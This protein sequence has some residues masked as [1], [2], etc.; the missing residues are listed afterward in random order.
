MT[1][2]LR[3]ADRGPY[4]YRLPARDDPAHQPGIATR[5]LPHLALAAYDAEAADPRDWA[6]P[7]TPELT[8]TVG[9][10]PA[11]FAP[12]ERPVHLREL[13]PFPGDALDPAW[14]GGDIVVQACATTPEA[15]LAA[16]PAGVTPRW[17]QTGSLRRARRDGPNTTPRD[18]LGFR[19]GSWNVR[20]DADRL[21][22][23]WIDRGDRTAMV[24]GTYMVVRRIEIDLE[25]WE[26][27]PVA[28]QERVIGRHK[29]TGAPLGRRSE[30]D[31]VV[32]EWLPRDSHALQAAPRSNNG[33][34]LLRRGYSYDRGVV[35]IAFTRDP[36]RYYVPMQR[37]L[38]E[39]DAL[40]G[41]TRHT[42]SA[43]FAVPP[44]RWAPG[45]RR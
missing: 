25:R 21:R 38:A 43:L 32:H 1:P 44:A 45:A 27:L 7:A 13:P 37:R 4:S 24:G 17:L 18:P 40:S 14:C 2:R 10:G 15:A 23:V 12:A 11:T 29:A 6:R 41:F 42:G 5:R 22:H 26:A 30:F 3:D 34:M 36:A 8:V 33:A 19:D 28:D 31:A 20:R 35:F 39:R 16:L 9:F